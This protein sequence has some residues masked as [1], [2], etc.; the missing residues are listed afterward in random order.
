VE[1]GHGRREVP[2]VAADF[3][4]DGILALAV[5]NEGANG[6]PVL[7]GTGNGSFG[8]TLYTTPMAR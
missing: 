6:V 2:I 1:P 5:A 8:P 4:A 3:N 7:L